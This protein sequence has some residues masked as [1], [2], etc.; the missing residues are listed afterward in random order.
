[1]KDNKLNILFLASWYPNAEFSQAGNFIQQHARAVSNFVN[2]CVLHVVPVKSQATFKVTKKWNENVYEVIVYYNKTNS[3]IP[4]FS[5]YQK[6]KKQQ[7]AYII[8]HQTALQELT[9][10]DMV[11]L[12]VVYPAG[13][14]ASLLLKKYKLP[15]IITEHWTAFQNSSNNSWSFIEKYFIK[16]ICNQ[17]LKIFPVSE[18][19]KNAMIDFGITNSFQVIPNV[20]N[21]NIFDSKKAYE[22]KDWIGILHVSNLKD[23]HKNISG[24]L[25]VI[26]KLSEKRKDFKLTIAGNGDI[27]KFQ[28]KAIELNIP[29][30][31]ILFEGEKTPKEVAHLMSQNDLFLLFSNYENLPCVIAESLIMGVP[32]LST[33]V[34]GIPEMINESNGVLINPGREDELYQSLDDMLNNI[35]KYDSEKITA[36]AKD[37]YSHHQIGEMYFDVYKSCLNK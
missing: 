9:Y 1:L 24:I 8:G 33:N 4:I 37:I 26:K 22:K 23:E 6:A 20:V 18:N 17:A 11:H 28:Q 34:G 12:N 25:S 2:V 35:T 7:E 31:V 32:V 29:R 3:T 36:R 16:K 15:F 5:N 10:F 30:E 27:E 19:L 21:T 13:L 14:F